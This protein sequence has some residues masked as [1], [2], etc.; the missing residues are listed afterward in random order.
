MELA[1]GCNNTTVIGGL[2]KYL[3]NWF[4]ENSHCMKPPEVIKSFNL[5]E[6]GYASLDSARRKEWILAVSD[7]LDRYEK[8]AVQKPPGQK[9]RSSGA[10]KPT[11]YGVD[12][13]VTI[14]K[15]V[16]TGIAPKL[17]NLGIDTVR[18]LLYFFPRRYIDYSNRKSIAE[19]RADMIPGEEGTILATIWE[20]N[21]VKLGKKKGTEITVGDKTGIAR[22][23]WFNQPFLARVFHTNDTILMT[24]KVTVYKGQI[25]FESPEWELVNAED[26]VQGNLLIPVYPLTSGIY[27]R[28]MRNLVKRAINDWL[29]GISEF[30]PDDVRTRKEF[31]GIGRAI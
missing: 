22:A 9:S 13:P 15:G 28:Q 1:N 8:S 10:E 7:W 27:P 24:G 29:G 11:E 16:K 30:L 19:L 6:S 4:R 25:V 5:G 12:S 23:V 20:S 26:M 3:S 18:D 21:V 2:D 17:H 14:I 31:P